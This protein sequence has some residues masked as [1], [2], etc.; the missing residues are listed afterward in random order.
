MFATW[1]ASGLAGVW[2][3]QNTRESIYDAFRR[4]ETFATT[5]PRIRVRFFASYGFGD[6]PLEDVELVEKAYEHGVP[7][8]GD[9]PARPGGEPRFLVWRC[10]TPSRRSSSACR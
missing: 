6:D 2:A 9:L 10:R 8:G 1:G 3:E 4:K 7:M 5:G